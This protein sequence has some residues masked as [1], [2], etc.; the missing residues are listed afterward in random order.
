MSDNPFAT[1]QADELPR[2]RWGR[3]LITPADGGEPVAYTRASTIG[4]VLEDTYNIQKW[5]GRMVALGMSKRKD[6]VARAASIFDPDDRAGKKTLNDIAERAKDSAAPSAA[7]LGSAVHAF[8][9]AVDQGAP[10]SSM[11]EDFQPDLRA[12][13]QLLADLGL[14]I[15]SMEQFIVVDADKV[16]GSYDRIYRTTR[17]LSV[18]TGGTE[19]TIPA[20]TYLIGDLKTGKN[21]VLGAGKFAVQLGAY[22]RGVAYN[23][24]TGSREPL[25]PVDQN[26]AIVIHLPVGQGV[27][28]AYLLNIDAGYNV[29]LQLAHQVRAWRTRKDIIFAITSAAPTPTLSLPEQIRAAASRDELNKIYFKNKGDWTA[30]LTSLTNDRLKEL[31]A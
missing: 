30:G 1:P 26:W 8:S 19:T 4:G 22:S 28:T 14:E 20:G 18:K 24:T 3:P 23:H 12:Y 16:G 5:F 21:A 31:G 11:P 27:A 9:E 10:I 15:V 25:P 13:V 7:E 2:D 29:G 17:E 6:L